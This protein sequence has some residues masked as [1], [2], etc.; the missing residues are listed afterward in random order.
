MNKIIF[1]AERTNFTPRIVNALLHAADGSIFEFEKG[2]YDFYA[3]GAYEGYFFPS[4]NRSGDK[5]VC[6]PLLNLNDITIDGGG[7]EFIFHDRLFPFI[8]QKCANIRLKNFSIDFSFPRYC[9][10]A[11]KSVSESAMELGIDRAIY[12][13]SVNTRKNLCVNAGSCEF[14]TGETRYF[15]NQ[16]GKCCYLSAGD[17]FYEN[18]ALP[19]PVFVCAAEE[20]ENGVILKNKGGYMPEFTAGERLV[21]S[22]D[23]R[24]ESDIFFFDR[25]KNSYVENVRIYRGAGM[26]IVGQCCENMT[27]NKLVIA[28]RERSGDVYSTTADGILLTN[29]SGRVTIENCVIDRTMDD[30]VSVHGYYTR[31]ER[32]TAYNKAVVR[33]MNKSQSGTNIYF[34]H[35]ILHITD[36]K[37]MDETGL[38]TVVSSR[39]EDDTYLIFLEFKEDITSLL[40]IGDLLENPDRTPEAVIRGSVFSDFP[41]IRIG[42]AKRVLFE[43]NTVRNS[44]GVG[45]LIN[46]IM[47]YW[48]ASGRVHNVVIRNNTF[49]NDRC[50]VGAVIQRLGD[51]SLKHENITVT[52]NE[53]INCGCNLDAESTDGL[54]FSNNKPDN[55]ASNVSCRNCLNVVV[56]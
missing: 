29:F 12:D 34:P 25:D 50:A 20:T 14:S 43:N 49:E 21:I 9:T 3:G 16:N 13:Y 8:I 32:I 37:T 56:S 22:Y 38:C 45:V 47:R 18:E 35:D 27:L 42:S 23:E 17:I 15:L 40:H 44:S 31:V 19:A 30:A 39:I 46:D 41:S 26:G 1:H 33:L 11:V 36:G 4:C 48:Y 51:T 55:A 5:K 28:P 6:F 2:T 7:S 53:F 54:I 52:G 24:R 10:A